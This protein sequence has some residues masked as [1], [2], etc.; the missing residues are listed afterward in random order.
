MQ[1]SSLQRYL[2]GKSL[3]NANTESPVKRI[4]KRGSE[5]IVTFADGTRQTF[6]KAGL[7]S[8]FTSRLQTE[9]AKAAL[10]SIRETPQGT[11]KV[12]IGGRVEGERREVRYQGH[13]VNAV[14][15]A[16]PKAVKDEVTSSVKAELAK[17]YVK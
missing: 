8:Q 3:P 1:P 4:E 14:R 11:H 10:K 13:A 7:V 12:T 9:Q 2:Q 6:S 16:Y 5:R 17:L 15:K